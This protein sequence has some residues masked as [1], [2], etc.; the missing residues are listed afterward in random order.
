MTDPTPPPA[1]QPPSAQELAK[2]EAEAV[3]L[4]AEARK[5]TAEAVTAEAEAEVAA[6][7]LAAA[8]EK[9]AA[10]CV[11]DDHCRIY[12]Y[13]ES[14]TTA[15]ADKCIATLARWH[16][17]TPDCDIEVIFNSPGGS[18]I[19]GMALFDA[20]HRLSLRGGGT[21]KLTIGV[22][23][24]AASMAGILVQAADVRWIG[25][26]S[27]FMIHEVSAGTGGKIG[28]MQ[29]DVKFYKAIC[30]RVVKIF[31]ARAGG[32]IT[33]AAFT[34]RWQRQDWWMLSDESL[35]LGFVDELR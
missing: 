12:R 35:K 13:N 1:P 8:R 16:R 31:V 23:G 9:E 3:K 17:L 6:I 10:R 33:K 27:Y 20:L 7:D 32:K 21:H 18:V 34:R 28:E 30:D 26:E 24:Y 19:A 5:V 15:S 14:V 25:R 4:L 2:L 22:A 29:D 11:S